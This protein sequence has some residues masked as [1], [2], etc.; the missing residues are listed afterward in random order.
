[1]NNNFY[2][3]P[4]AACLAL[5]ISPTIVNAAEPV[6]LPQTSFTDVQQNFQLLLPQLGASSNQSVDALKL[7]RQHTDTNK[8]TH[9]RMQQQYAGFPV[10]GGYAIM[11]SRRSL[12]TLSSARSGVKMTGVI[13]RGLKA[14]LGEPSLTFVEHGAVALQQFKEQFQHQSISDEQVMPMVYVDDKHN[15]FWAYK[16]SVLVSHSDNIPERPTAIIDAQTLKPFL[17]WNDLKTLHAAV[18]G[19]GFGGNHVTGKYQYGKDLPLLKLTRHH[20]SAICYMENKDVKVVDMGFKYTGSNRAMHFSCPQSDSLPEKTYW[21]GYQADGYDRINGAYSP[22]NDALY[23]GQVIKGMYREWYGLDVLTEENEPM[24]L[25]MRV[26][27]GKGYENAYWDGRQMTFGD[28]DNMMHPLVSLGIGAHE[29]S[30][31]FTEQH[32]DLEYY[33]QSGGM[34]EAFSDMAAQAAEYYSVGKS[35]WTIG[36]EVMK[37]DSGYEALRFMEEPSRDGRSIDRADQYRVGMDVHHSSG[38]YNHLFYLLS[39]QPEWTVNQAFH[40]MVKA[41]MDYW[42]PYSTFDDGSCG[43]INAVNDLGLSVD[44]VKQVLDQVK[45]NYLACNESQELM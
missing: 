30:H 10:F 6:L 33:G 14:E 20:S 15:A 26:H 44:D 28:G 40:V 1:M 35:S 4:L 31:G 39:N 8:I 29:I 38:V 11:H 36:A 12:Q 13:Y 16:V 23:A 24:Q 25:V 32:S 41:N 22:S 7:V 18:S 5:A 42:T 21:A 27:F 34:N 37:E 2:L 43:I 17:Q 45:V 3:S 9:V 19:M